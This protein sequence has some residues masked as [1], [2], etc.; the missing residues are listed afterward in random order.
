VNDKRALATTTKTTT[1]TGLNNFL[2]L[3]LTPFEMF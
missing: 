3:N 2:N 1:V